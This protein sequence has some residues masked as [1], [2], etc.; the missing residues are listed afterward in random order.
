MS[1]SRSYG[2]ARSRWAGIGPYYAMFPVHFA[3]ET[4][5]QYTQPG[6][7]V[8]DP[9]AGRGTAVF[10]AATQRR[11]SIGV[12]INPVG[13][14]YAKAKLNAAPRPAV[15]RCLSSVAE[16][17][18]CFAEDA[19]D[20]PEFFHW[21]FSPDVRRFLLSARANLH[22]RRRKVDQTTMALLLVYL[23][24]KAGAAL[25][26]QLRQTK[27]MAP[28][29]AV[30]WWR[31]R[32]LR[33]PDV[34]PLGFLKRRLDWRYAKGTPDAAGG[35][36]Y[37]GNSVDKLS[38]IQRRIREGKSDRAKLLLTSPPYHSITHYYYD[39]WLRLWLLGGPPNANRTAE[40]YGQRFCGR[41][42]YKNLLYRVFSK[43]AKTMRDDGVVYVRT[44][45]REFTYRTTI[46][47]L[48]QVFPAKKMVEVP[49]PLS[50]PSQTHLFGDV[51]RSRH[52]DGE[53]DLI[54][55]PR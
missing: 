28:R 27:A 31:E 2:D 20:L 41:I 25:S 51:S 53:V 5:R 29:Y 50:K 18:T 14:V 47:V 21:C 26:N 9:F 24:G 13:Y 52:T 15:D 35:R 1:K 8:L 36:M 55:L 40:G 7:L 45:S 37:L 6:D 11:S 49:R 4:V 22:W 34:D 16:Q 46:S 39:Q 32:G 23:H 33:P 19:D 3:D 30:R 38:Q 44:D 17:A 10:S 48:E 43:S 42:A 12:D 54:L